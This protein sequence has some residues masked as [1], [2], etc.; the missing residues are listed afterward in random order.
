V[1][2]TIAGLPVHVL[3]IHGV[4]VLL[5]LMAL[6]TVAWAWWPNGSMRLGWAVVAANA[7][8]A[9]MTLVAKQSG[10]AL[11]RRLSLPGEPPVAAD[12]QAIAQFLPWFA[13]ALFLAA[14][15]VQLVRQGSAHIPAR[16]TGV[17]T[18]VIAL[19]VVVWTVRAGHSG[20]DAV[21]GEIVRNTGN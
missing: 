21:W 6:V 12:H 17:A 2:D 4:V 14:L 20:S 9:A 8:V 7:A 10:E 13:L 1:F 5:P 3:V 18:A 19:A 11:Q 16:L 15:L